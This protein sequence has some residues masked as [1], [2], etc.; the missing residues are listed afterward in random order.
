M[1]RVD[2]ILGFVTRIMFTMA[3]DALRSSTIETERLHLRCLNPIRDD[4]SN[5]LKG[6]RD[7]D[8]S[9]FIITARNDFQ[10]GEIIDFVTKINNDS[11]FLLLGIFLRN[12]QE[13]IGNI[14]FQISDWGAARAEIGIY[15]WD[16]KNRSNGFGSES[17]LGSTKF[18]LY[19]L[20]IRTFWL[21][22]H[23]DNIKAIETYTR[24]GFRR[25]HYNKATNSITMT[26]E[27]SDEVD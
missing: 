13:H 11:N 9:P 20:G 4:F 18:L 23:V 15:V 8:G 25:T 14:K 22:V 5:Y 1:S 27:L 17:I 26:W 10:L 6:M 3:F 7:I 24:I 12:S 2:P 21:G 16:L 19:S